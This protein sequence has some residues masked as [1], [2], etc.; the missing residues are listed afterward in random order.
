MDGPFGRASFMIIL[1]H[2][3]L[4]CM[5]HTTLILY[6]TQQRLHDLLNKNQDGLLD[7]WIT[8]GGFKTFQ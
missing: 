4:P 6:Y 7:Y 8:D 1:K 5:C 3:V 2:L